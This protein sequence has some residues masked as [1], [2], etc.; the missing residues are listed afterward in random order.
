MG[1][2]DHDVGHL[3][4]SPRCG[5][6]ADTVLRHERVTALFGDRDSTSRQGHTRPFAFPQ[7]GHTIARVDGRLLCRYPDCKICA[8]SPEFAP[9]H[10]DCFETFR[11]QCSVSASR[12]LSRLR[13][14]AAWRNPWRGAQPIHLSALM[15][16]KETLRTISGF[17]GLPHLQ[18]LP[19]ELL[20][21]IRQYSEHSLLWRCIP[22]LQLAD[23]VSATEP[24]PLLAVLP[25]E[26]LFWKRGGKFER[27][28]PSVSLIY[29]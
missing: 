4:L 20:E 9:I 6:C 14:L 23:H 7:P 28:C 13:I 26:I 3:G 22:A 21:T 18:T 16:D 11:Q 29:A 17:R 25:R 27:P 10:F 5:I 2:S 15:L 8:A 1:T 24:E 12:A 19:S